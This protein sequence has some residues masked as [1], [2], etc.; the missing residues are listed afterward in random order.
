MS[1]LCAFR[2]SR[3]QLIFKIIC[4]K[5][6]MKHIEILGS[7]SC[8]WLHKIQTQVLSS[9]AEE[10]NRIE[11]QLYAYLCLLSNRNIH[12]ASV[13]VKYIFVAGT[14][15]FIFMGKIAVRYGN[16]GRK[17][18]LV[19]TK[20]LALGVPQVFNMQ[21]NSTGRYHIFYRSKCWP[22]APSSS[23]SLGRIDPEI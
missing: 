10:R 9:V 22:W 18:I 16:L 14:S 19:H 8:L 21:S 11:V 13:N 7:L 5:D 12:S 2:D 23:A 15:F 6:R 20:S 4:A 3:L 17:E 1:V